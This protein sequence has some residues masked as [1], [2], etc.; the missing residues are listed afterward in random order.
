M[1]VHTFSVLHI[2]FLRLCCLFLLVWPALLRAQDVGTGA[3]AGRIVDSWQG[4]PLVGVTVVVRGTTVGTT[5]DAAGNYVVAKLPPGNYSL[6]FSRSGYSKGS[7][8]DVRVVAGQKTPGDYSLKPEFFELEVFEAVSEPVLEQTTDIL[9]GRQQAV[10]TMEALGSEQLAKLGANDAAEALTKVTGASLVDGKF[11]VIRGLSDRYTSATLNSMEI[12]SADPYRKSAQ[13]DMFPSSMIER[14]EVNKTFTPDQP[15]GFTGGS[16]NIVTKTIPDKFFFKMSVG[17][18]YNT[19]TTGQEVLASPGGSTD[20]LGMDD[21]TRAMP[22]AVANGQRIPT[23]L[24]ARFN[25][26]DRALLISQTKSFGLKQ[27]SPTKE[28]APANHNFSF[29]SGD[30]VKV[31]EGEMGY[32]ATLSYERKY[33]GYTDGTYERYT[34]IGIDTFRQEVA[35]KQ[36]KGVD[37]VGWGTAVGL[38]YKVGEANELS[39]TFLNTQTAENS[40]YRIS[41]L[42]SVDFNSLYEATTLQYTERNLRSFLFGGKHEFASLKN[43]EFDWNVAYTTTTQDDPDLRV[44]AGLHS[45]SGTYFDNSVYPQQPSRYWR[46]LEEQNV[47]YRVDA[48]LPFTNWTEEEGKVKVGLNTS[49]SDRKF[50]QQGFAYVSQNGFFPWSDDGDFN[51]LLPVMEDVL[52]AGD[53]RPFYIRRETPNTYKGSQTINASYGMLEM[54]LHEKLKFIGGARLESTDLEV[55]SSGGSFFATQATSAIRQN[56][57]LPALGLI[58]SPVTNV[59]LRLNFSETVARPTYREIANVAT[60]DY[61]GGEILVGNPA[62][63]LTAIKNYDFRAEWYPSPGNLFS[64]GAFYKELAKPIELYYTRL[65]GNE[66]SYTNRESATVIG[67]EAEARIN[68]G[69]LSQEL[70]QFTLGVNYAWIYSET[71][72]TSVEYANKK[73]VESDVSQTRPMYDQSPFILNADLTYDNTRTKTTVTLSYNMTGP[74]LAIA[75][76]LGPDIYEHPGDS[77]DLSISQAISDHWKIRFSAKNLLNPIYERTVGL[78]KVRP[79]SSYTKGMEFGISLSCSF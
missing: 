58:Y 36:S 26:A 7:L 63:T 65:D 39:F 2:S 11:A 66:S 55:N 44:I 74:R 79:Y 4:N 28:T 9:I 15:G 32:Y 42:N 46:S 24:D 29:A 51:D 17:M 6:V 12:P 60:F 37:E 76:P 56:D 49:L 54:P 16:V 10:V 25:A 40:A 75:N 57:L 48:A 5:T 22:D 1:N 35:A 67:W 41:G 50:D 3:I 8:N 78:D 14:I 30:K 34:P 70:D 53:H 45:P 59:N 52:G 31:G 62:L 68:L 33:K 72:L 19:Q 73:T 23:A 43:L 27:M 20:W 38:G 71:S 13:L 69:M 77:L 47:N 61:I 21:G 18:S 64:I